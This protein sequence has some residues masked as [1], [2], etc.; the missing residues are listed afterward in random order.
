MTSAEKN[1][2]RFT[3]FAEVYDNARPALPQH[4]IELVR[5]YLGHEIGNVADL[6][7]G[8]GLS[9]AAWKGHCKCVTGVEP[10]D[11]MLAIA[12]SKECSGVSFIK[13][14]SHNTGL[15]D[16]S[17][18]AVVCSQSFHWMEPVSTL[19][20]ADRLLVSGGVFATVDCD[21]PPVCGTEPECAYAEL[22]AK[23][24]KLQSEVPDISST[25]RRW[26]KSGHLANIR[27]SGQFRYVRELVFANPEPF[28]AQRFINI[29][30]SQGG[31]QTILKLHPELI[32]DEWNE[33]QRKVNE[34]FGEP[35]MA[36]FCYRVR[37]G[38]K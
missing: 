13:G 3:G 11:D 34:C 14:Y 38:V 30:E 31:L 35:R 7:C 33:F 24:D 15:P 29:A 26:E 8:T 27:S 23:V 5:L 21:W 2:N 4:F 10:S 32:E 6:G 28:T 1:A 19:K 25:F 16:C 22:F 36:E 18:D 12:R 37:L 17:M 9:T 20:E